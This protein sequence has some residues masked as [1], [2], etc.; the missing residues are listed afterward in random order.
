MSV[1]PIDFE[2]PICLSNEALS[3][4]QCSKGHVFHINCLSQWAVQTTQLKNIDAVAC[5][6]CQEPI[7]IEINTKIEH[8]KVR[9]S[10]TIEKGTS[11][12]ERA[13]VK[14]SM[15]TNFYL[16][17][18]LIDLKPLVD[19]QS[20]SNEDLLTLLNENPS[21]IDDT[22]AEYETSLN[23]ITPIIEDSQK[24]VV[25]PLLFL[26][27]LMITGMCIEALTSKCF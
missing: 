15:I 14:D 12:I 11:L 21:L 6:L 23:A 22:I 8:L 26:M 17:T 9:I 24:L 19:L 3:I 2:C 5:L 16:K 27:L 10:Q 20:N 4:K 18:L 25:Q 7:P 13:K 1:L